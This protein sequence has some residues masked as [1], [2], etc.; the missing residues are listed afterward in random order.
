M[1]S[2]LVLC[3]LAMTAIGC[4]KSPERTG[5]LGELPPVPNTATKVGEDLY[6]VPI[7]K[8]ENGCIQYQLFSQTQTTVS[9]ISLRD[10]NGNFT[11]STQLPNC[12]KG[13]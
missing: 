6:Y 1:R 2:L 8:D 11:T 5:L 3:V 9:V 7:S 12:Y 4:A 10:L 13:P